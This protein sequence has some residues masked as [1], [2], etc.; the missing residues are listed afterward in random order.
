M[1]KLKIFTG[2][3]NPDLTK[4]ICKYLDLPLACATVDRFSD[5]EIEVKLS[6]NVRGVDVFIVQ[7]TCPPAENLLELFLIIDAAHR[8]SAKR[9]TAVIPYFG[10]ARQDKKDAPR[11]PI[12]SKLIANL[13]RTAGTDRVLT[14]DL[15][16]TQI[17]GFFDIPVDHLY[18]A[19]V[20]IDCFKQK[21]L[22]K[23]VIASPDVGGAKRAEG[24]AK[25]MGNLPLAI[26]NKRRPAPDQAYVTNVVGEVKDKDVLIIDDIISTGGTIVNAAQALK[27]QGANDI[28]CYCTHPILSG[29][30]VYKIENSELNKLYVTDTIPLKKKADKIEVLSVANLLGEAILRIHQETSISSLFV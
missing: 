4:R 6:E 5:G 3:S 30:A 15:H 26:I 27:A 11:V 20:I 18:A 21:G 19:P 7:S 1:N 17:Q 14:M 28:Y 16:A 23:L 13:I 22:K 24:I 25:R 10:Y 8:A 2:N 9:I 29:D 12:S